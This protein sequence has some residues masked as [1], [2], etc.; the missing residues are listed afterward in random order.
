MAIMEA[1]VRG[2]PV[3]A[4]AVGGN[5]EIIENRKT[6]VLL[7]KATPQHFLKEIEYVVKNYELVSAFSLDRQKEYSAKKLSNQL[8]D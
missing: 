5:P 6:G 3:I 7:K 8:I 4:P 1:Q 2:I